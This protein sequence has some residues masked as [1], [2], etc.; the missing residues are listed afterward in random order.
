MITSR[1]VP[2]VIRIASVGEVGVAVVDRVIDALGR[3]ASCLEAEAVPKIS[4]PIFFAIWVA[5]I[6]TP[7]AAAWIRT[8]SSDLSPPMITSAA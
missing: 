4:A 8:R 2:P 3:I 6:P 5:A 7:P 1:P